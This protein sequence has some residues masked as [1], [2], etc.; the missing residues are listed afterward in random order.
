MNND[1]YSNVD[2][3][4]LRTRFVRQVSSTRNFKAI[5]KIADFVHFSSA[6]L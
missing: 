6:P 3:E 2:Y 5:R 4:Y 1:Q